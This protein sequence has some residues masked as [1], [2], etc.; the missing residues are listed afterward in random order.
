MR[1]LG[2]GDIVYRLKRNGPI[3]YGLCEYR[4]TAVT[5]C[6]VWVEYLRFNGRPAH[7]YSWRKWYNPNARHPFARRTVE[8]A[9]LSFAARLRYHS[10]RCREDIAANDVLLRRLPNDSE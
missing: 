7:M 8:D 9:T 6:G 3:N 4:V 2:V 5:R 10:A 1:E